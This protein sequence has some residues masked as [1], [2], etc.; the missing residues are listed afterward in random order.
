[1][2]P[3]PGPLRPTE[4]AE[5]DV[6]P[7]LSLVVL[8]WNE[9]A[10]VGP[11]LTQT[12]Q[13]LDTRPGQHEIIVVDDGSTDRTAEIVRGFAA[14]DPRVR[15]VSHAVNR[16]MGG[17][18]RSGFASA[19]GDYVTILAADG[20]VRASEID[21]LLPHLHKATIVSSI[22]TRRPSERY[23]VLMSAGLRGLMRALIGLS[24]QLE[25]IYLF[26]VKLAREEI[27]LD[28]IKAETFFFSFELISRAIQRGETVYVTEVE[29]L[30]RMAGESKVANTSRIKRVATELLAFRRQLRAEGSLGIFG[31]K[32]AR[33]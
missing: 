5:V 6:I 28:T 29:P 9:E 33:P 15:L 12:L 7:K 23:R 22:Y 8:A 1:M 30:P 2:G 24:F 11:F 13:W 19:R 25:G 17:G 32:A 10:S 21:K 20:Q 31:L 4:D 16:G 18:M 26:P 3:E 14:E 27:G